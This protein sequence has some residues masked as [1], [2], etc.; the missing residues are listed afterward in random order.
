L[1]LMG[2]TKEI[3]T[4]RMNYKYMMW[5]WIPTNDNYKYNTLGLSLIYV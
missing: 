2:G 1:C 5:G 4:W 3:L